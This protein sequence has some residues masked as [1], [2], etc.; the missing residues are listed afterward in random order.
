MSNNLV[1]QCGSKVT[2]WCSDGNAMESRILLT[3][4]TFGIVVT[5]CTGDNAVFVPWNMVK[6]ID[7]QAY[8][9]KETK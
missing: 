4:D 8:G 3:L 5:A 1:D 6:Y 9:S 2:V 7:Y